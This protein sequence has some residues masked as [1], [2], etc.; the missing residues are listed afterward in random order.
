MDLALFLD[1][2]GTLLEHQAHPDAVKVDETLR[3]LIRDSYFKL[4]G[5]L[6]LVTGRSIAMADRL[7]LPL[8]LP[9]A[10]LY[11]V[12]MRLK[13]GEPFSPSQESE[14]FTAVIERLIGRFKPVEGIYFE[15]KGAILAIHTRAAP[16]HLPEVTAA[17][18]EAL[19]E[20]ENYRIIAGHAGLEMVPIGVAKA[21]AIETFMSMAPFK[22]RR[23]VFIGDDTSD[24]SGFEQV[25]KT[26]GV[27][28]RVKPEG[29]TAARETLPNVAAVHEWIRK[30][31]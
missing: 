12:E 8:E 28:I 11:G 31:I 3:A 24:E 29:P 4:D 18:E 10:G 23:P 5:A 1:I 27:S 17:A 14:A 25:N 7:F 16:D 19:P 26:G 20:L 2:D 9:V 30:N 21:A 22:G 15:R 13:P 6:A